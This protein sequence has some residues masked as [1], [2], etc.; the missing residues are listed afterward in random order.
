MLYG[1]DQIKLV[2]GNTKQIIALAD[3]DRFDSEEETAEE[4]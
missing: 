3:D 2:C 4:E 1:K